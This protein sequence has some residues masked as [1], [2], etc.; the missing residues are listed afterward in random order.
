MP[1]RGCDD[2]DEALNRE[3]IECCALYQDKLLVDANG[4]RLY[5]LQEGV[6]PL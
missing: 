4:G 1:V 5:T 3:E 6:F 2:M